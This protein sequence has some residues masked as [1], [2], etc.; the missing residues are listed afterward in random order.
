MADFL[1]LDQIKEIINSN[2]SHDRPKFAGLK[3]HE[4]G[5]YNSA[6]MWGENGEAFGEDVYRAYCD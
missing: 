5:K 4:I 2:Y 1:T 3:S 6:M